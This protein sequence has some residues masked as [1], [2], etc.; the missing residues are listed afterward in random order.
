MKALALS[1]SLFAAAALL[2]GCAN[3]ASASGE[4]LSGQAIA[5]NGMKPVAHVNA[6]IYGFYLF[7]VVPLASGDP[8]DGKASLFA[9]NATLDKALGMLCS[10][11]GELGSTA[12]LDMSSRTVSRG[13][14]S[15]WIVWY[16]E[17][18]ISGNAVK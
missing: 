12:V 5:S 1:A 10:K 2:S 17:A 3:F 4:S 16:R 6:S 18:Q 9:N 11:S 14:W 7:G 13:A 15:F 8:K